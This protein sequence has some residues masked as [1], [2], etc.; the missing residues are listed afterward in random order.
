MI[1]EII[2]REIGII[3][4]SLLLTYI[5]ETILSFFIIKTIKKGKS[6]KNTNTISKYLMSMFNISMVVRNTRNVT[7]EG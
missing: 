3:L 2:E 7:I 6:E 5:S 4:C 1:Y